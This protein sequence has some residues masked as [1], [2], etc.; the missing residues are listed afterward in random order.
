ML[1]IRGTYPCY[2]YTLNQKIVVTTSTFAGFA[3]ALDK[4][5]VTENL[6]FLHCLCVISQQLKRWFRS[7]W[8]QWSKNCTS[9]NSR[10]SKTSEK[11]HLHSPQPQGTLYRASLGAGRLARQ[12][13]L[14]WNTLESASQK[15]SWLRIL[16]FTPQDMYFLLAIFTP[17]DIFDE[18]LAII[19][20][21]QFDQGLQP[22]VWFVT[23]CAF[24]QLETAFSAVQKLII[25]IFRTLF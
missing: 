16:I 2:C 15:G 22:S 14:V 21:D 25:Q 4:L 17:Q 8:G 24:F 5:Y 1:S 18:I 12:L 20:Q 23:N 9:H 7:N 10:G 11:F 19:I 6:S 3:L 13:G